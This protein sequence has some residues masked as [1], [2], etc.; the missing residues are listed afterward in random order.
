MEWPE[1]E[2]KEVDGGRECV[3]TD[4]FSVDSSHNVS[5]GGGGVLSRLSSVD[6]GED[7]GKEDEG[8]LE[9]KN[10]ESVLGGFERAAES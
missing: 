10:S 1:V 7:M 2:L 3:K 6:G 5:S 8:A 4:D 9:G